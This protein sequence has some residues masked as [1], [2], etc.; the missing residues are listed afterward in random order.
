MYKTSM[1][2]QEITETFTYTGVQACRPNI[3]GDEEFRE[4]D[5][6]GRSSVLVSGHDEK[7]GTNEPVV[8]GVRF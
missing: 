6:E 4:L 5:E 3:T 2:R 7:Y 8:A 1:M